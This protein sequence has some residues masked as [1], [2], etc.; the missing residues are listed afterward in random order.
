MLRVGFAVLGC[1]LMRLPERIQHKPSQDAVETDNS[2][3]TRVCQAVDQWDAG[4][5]PVSHQ[6][7]GNEKKPSTECVDIQLAQESLNQAGVHSTREKY[8]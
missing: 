1:V 3:Q 4:V 2:E 5:A 7:V 8:P 6:R